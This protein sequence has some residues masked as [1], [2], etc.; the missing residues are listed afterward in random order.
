MPRVLKTA[1][2]PIKGQGGTFIVLSG[3]H[4]ERQTDEDGNQIVMI[5]KP[6][7]GEFKSDRPLDVLFQNK[8]ERVGEKKVRKPRDYD[9]TFESDDMMDAPFASRKK[10]LK[11][12]EA[13]EAKAR[14]MVM[15][16]EVDPDEEDDDEVQAHDQYSEAKKDAGV[17]GKRA[18]VPGKKRKQAEEEAESDAEEASTEEESG[19]EDTPAK[20]AAAK[21]AKVKARVKSKK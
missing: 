15:R 3:N 5:Y 21:R 18:A 11:M 1:E 17:Y 6:E 13:A 7:D 16:G 14:K 9:Q 2:A 19:E 20:R 4:A 8:F 12:R 10:K